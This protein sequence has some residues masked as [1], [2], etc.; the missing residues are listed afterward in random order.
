MRRFER[1]ASAG[2]FRFCP[3]DALLHCAFADEKRARDLRHGETR[4][5]T[6]RERDLLR[7]RQ[8]RMAAD[9]QQAQDVV[10]IVG[11]IKPLHG[12]GFDVAQ[13][14]NLVL[15]GQ[16]CLLRPAAG[17]IDRRVA[18]D[19]DEPGGGIAWRAVPGP[20]LQRPQAGVLISLLGQ[21]EVAEIPQQRRDRLGP[22][23][24]KRRVDPGEVGHV[25][26]PLRANQDCRA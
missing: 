25:S 19:H 7:R 13:I 10:A 11:F 26:A 9:E 23:G 17:D 3:R 2:H 8:V 14:G 1:H 12:L 21:I 24:H 18:A 22:R 4:D 16:L 6:E 15:V 5:D 20:I